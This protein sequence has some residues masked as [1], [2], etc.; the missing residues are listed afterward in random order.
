MEGIPCRAASYFVGLIDENLE[1]NDTMVVM[2]HEPEQSAMATAAATNKRL[3]SPQ[4][5]PSHDRAK[6][7]SMESLLPDA[8]AVEN[9][10]GARNAHHMT[11]IAKQVGARCRWTRCGRIFTNC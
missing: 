10:V 2:H 3:N 1:D 11:E 4:N 8:G 7:S 6:L 5:I 9:L